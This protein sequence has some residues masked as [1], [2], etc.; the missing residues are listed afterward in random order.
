MKA[1]YKTLT[2]MIGAVAMTGALFSAPAYSEETTVRVGTEPSFAPFEFMDEKTK[3]LTGFDIDLINAIGKAS[4]FKVE[5]H[6]MPFDGI[7]PAILTGSLDAALSAFTITDE[8]KKRVD[9]SEP[10]YKAGLGVIIRNA[11]KDKV[12]SVDDLKC[13]KL[14]GQI[15]TSGAMY[16]SKIEGATVTQFNTAPETYLE[17]RK[18]GCDAVINDRPVHAYYMATVRP[19]DLTLLPDY[20]TAEDYGIVMSKSEPEIEKLINDGLA[21]IHADGTYDKIYKKWFGDAAE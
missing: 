10:Y 11:V 1:F 7:I 12:K 5:M 9:F 14:C 18:G 3:E 21:K 6:T 17:L 16:A 20:V 15:G 4:G 8:R 2:S 13:M 19:D